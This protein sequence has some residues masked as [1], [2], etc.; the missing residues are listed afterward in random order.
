MWFRFLPVPKP[1]HM[2][3]NCVPWLVAS[4]FT[5]IKSSF[6]P[7]LWALCPCSRCH[8]SFSDQRR[9]PTAQLL[10]AG[11]GEGNLFAADFTCQIRLSKVSKVLACGY[12][13]I[14]SAWVCHH[15]R[16]CKQSGPCR[17]KR[18]CKREVL[19]PGKRGSKCVGCC[20][21]RFSKARNVLINVWTM[22]WFLQARV[23]GLWIYC[24]EPLSFRTSECFIFCE[25]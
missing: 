18:R 2:P 15:H 8:R 21:E 25:T 13:G 9:V 24:R 1:K 20:F 3:W 4:L 16:A 23:L 11:R 10:L 7:R 5:L 12:S 6:R 19:C 22:N 17:W 14:V